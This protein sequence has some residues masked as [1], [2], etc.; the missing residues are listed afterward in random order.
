MNC[1]SNVFEGPAAYLDPRNLPPV[2]LIKLPPELNPFSKEER[3]DIYAQAA[4]LWPLGSLK[5][6]AVFNM[7]WAAHQRGQLEGKHTITDSSSGNTAYCE[8]RLARYWGRKA[9]LFFPSDIA[10]TKEERLR[11]M[12]IEVELIKCFDRPGELTSMEL[13]CQKGQEKGYFYLGQYQNP[14]NVGGHEKYHIQPAWEQTKG[15]MTVYAGGL[16]TCGHIGAA[17]KFF[18]KTGPVAVVGAYCAAGNPVPGLRTLDRLKSVPLAQSLLAKPLS[19]GL[20]DMEVRQHETYKSSAELAAADI[21]GGPTSGSAKV[22]LEK[23]L[24]IQRRAGAWDKFRNA[25]GR[26]VAVFMCGDSKD[27]YSDE[28]YR[29]ILDQ[30]EIP[31]ANPNQNFPDFQ[32]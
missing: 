12:G 29:T 21:R 14:D 18:K 19:S 13:A 1:K 7:L 24:R 28:K 16:G 11:N 23:F 25:D 2:P 22:A 6:P 20:Y 15:K 8:A 27:L 31:V 26:I 5:H 32:I 4:Y 3:V 10:S 17:L 30:D 9:T